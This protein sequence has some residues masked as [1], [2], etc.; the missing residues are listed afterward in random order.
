MFEDDRNMDLKGTF[1]WQEEEKQRASD[2]LTMDE[3]Q[4]ILAEIRF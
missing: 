3:I 4:E 2:S 1:S